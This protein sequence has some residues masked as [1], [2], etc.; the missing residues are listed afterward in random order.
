MKPH[1]LSFSRNL[2]RFSV[3]WPIEKSSE[4]ALAIHP[5]SFQPPTITHQPAPRL[6]GKQKYQRINHCRKFT[7]IVAGDWRAPQKLGA[8]ASV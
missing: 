6:P 2:P 4:F 8:A 5:S 3:E 1:P 7:R